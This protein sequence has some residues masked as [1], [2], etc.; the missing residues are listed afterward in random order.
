VDRGTNEPLATKSASCLRIWASVSTTSISYSCLRIWF[1]AA[2]SA[3]RYWEDEFEREGV[4][5]FMAQYLCDP[6]ERFEAVAFA[7]VEER[8]ERRVN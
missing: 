2:H 3:E 5:D 4:V 8:D 7:G 6:A 1:N